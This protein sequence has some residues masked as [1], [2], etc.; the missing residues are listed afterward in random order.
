[1]TALV[2]WPDGMTVWDLVELAAADPGSALL[3]VVSAAFWLVVLGAAVSIAGYLIGVCRRAP[4]SDAVIARDPS[5]LTA[6]ADAVAEGPVADA[7]VVV[8]D[9]PDF[10]RRPRPVNERR[11]SRWAARNGNR[12]DY[13]TE[14]SLSST[15]QNA[16][17]ITRRQQEQEAQLGI[18]KLERLL[19][20]KAAET[21]TTQEIKRGDPGE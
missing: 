5:D 2:D 14:A 6:V 21:E 1:M 13:F 3:G 12:G 15:A 7:G 10:V 16:D 11:D 4:K 8:Q 17:W 18:A 20:A 19:A 9:G